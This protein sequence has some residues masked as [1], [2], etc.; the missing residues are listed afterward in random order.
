MP[1][2]D[3]SDSRRYVP[4]VKFSKCAP[5]LEL[6]RSRPVPECR[7]RPVLPIVAE[8][9]ISFEPE[10]AMTFVL[11]SE[12]LI[13]PPVHWNKPGAQSNVSDEAFRVPL[14]RITC[15]APVPWISPVQE[16]E[17]PPVKSSTAPADTVKIPLELLPLLASVSWPVCTSKVPLMLLNTIVSMRDSLVPPILR[18]TE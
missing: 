9:V 13:W 14:P 11:S 12:P 15:P 18:T 4:D 7:T 3:A 17:R 5:E 8:R 16:G 2:I 10:K 6:S 1:A